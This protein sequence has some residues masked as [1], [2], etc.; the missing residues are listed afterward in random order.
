MWGWLLSDALTTTD[1][2][3]LSWS[4][5][6][7]PG[8]PY[9]EAAGLL[10]S[11]L[12]TPS[13]WQRDGGTCADRVAGWLCRGIGVDGGLGRDGT[14][15]LFDSSVV[16][17][18]LLRYRGAG[19]RAG[20][21]DAVHRLHGFVARQITRGLAVHPASASAD[22]RWSTQFGAHLLKCLHS[23]HLYARVFERPLRE[24]LATTLIHR[25]G[26]QPSPVYVHPFCYEQEGHLI[27]AHSGLVDLFEPIEGAL[28]WLAVLQQPDGAILSFANGLDGFG[29]ARTDVTAQAARL[30]LLLDRVR[31]AD[32]IA[33]AFAFL[34]GCQ[35]PEGG[36]R[37]APGSADICSWSTLF[38]LQAVEWFLDEP[39]LDHLL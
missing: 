35:T 24:D 1:G 14:A 10:L 12:S 29:E 26:H 17:A 39:H 9:A 8:Y 37:Y 34:S 33:R 18:G 32:P 19:G 28:D 3:I 21:D 7:H 2:A 30:W 36:I 4:N 38:A 27:V 31:Y 13:G 25:S 6:R 20:V 11:A 5:P 23:L 16:L 15:Y 22:G